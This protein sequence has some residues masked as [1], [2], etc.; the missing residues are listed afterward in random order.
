M[1]VMLIEDESLAMDELRHLMK[2]YEDK[3]E[4]VGFDNGED[5]L[6][7]ALR[8]VPD[9]VISDIR[10]PGLDGLEVIRRL[11]EQYP[12]LQAVML[13]GYND[14]EYARSALKLGAKEYLLKPVPAPELYA[15]MDRMVEAA[16]REEKKSRQ[17]RNWT[18]SMKVRG[19]NGA[20]EEAEGRQEPIGDWIMISVLLDNWNSPIIWPQNETSAVMVAEWLRTEIHPGADCFDMDEHLRM[21]LIPAVETDRES[22]IRQKANRIHDFIRR[23]AN[24]V[25]TAYRLK[26]SRESMKE[27]YERCLQLLESQVRLGEST[28]MP[29]LGR[30]VAVQPFWDGARRIEQHVRD[31][32][33]AKMQMELRRLLDVLRREGIT[34]KQ[35]S[36]LLSDLFYALKFKFSDMQSEL[37]AVDADSIYDYLKTCQG[38]EMVLALL[39]ERM[40]SLMADSEHVLPNPKQII[41]PLLD[42]IQQHYG[43]SVQLKDFAAKYHVSIGYLSKLFKSETGDH[44][45][46]YLIR[47]RMNKAQELLDTGYKKITEIGKLVGYEDP[48]HFSQTFK[49]WIGVTPQQYKRNEQ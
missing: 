14:F 23:S 25:H 10:M 13:S 19:L 31:A 49:R 22:G 17:E 21:I 37:E 48:K 39:T 26:T 44:F 20:G 7:H 47:V 40:A 35:S 43:E 6:A 12:R 9:I 18:L 16:R 4:I 5:A 24:V 27:T 3:H 34:L 33:Y 41:P 8:W 46:D 36:V 32:E 28:F 11:I 30:S 45:S 29:V 2:P 15:A 42:Y 38:D 1:K